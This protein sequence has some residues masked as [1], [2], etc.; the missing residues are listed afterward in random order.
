MPVVWQAAQVWERC[1]WVRSH[2]LPHS[3]A[4]TTCSGVCA[5]LVTSWLPTSVCSAIQ[6]AIIG[7]AGCLTKHTAWQDFKA[8]GM[9]FEVMHSCL[10][11]AW[12]VMLLFKCD[13]VAFVLRA[14]L[15]HTWLLRC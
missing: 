2:C 8:V 1:S 4:A 13:R 7:K 3:P 11:A 6:P 10:A 5:C 15:G 14:N 12:A 9:L